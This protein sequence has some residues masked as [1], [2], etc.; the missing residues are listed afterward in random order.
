MLVLARKSL[1]TIRIGDQ[2]TIS[3]VSI[4]GRIVRLGIEAP[5]DL[6]IIRGELMDRDPSESHGES[7]AAPSGVGPTTAAHSEDASSGTPELKPLALQAILPVPRLTTQYVNR[8]LSLRRRPQ[9]S[10]NGVR[11][12]AL[13]V[14]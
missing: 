6:R 4:K 3:V 5:T 9:N 14:S 11:R 7:L 13:A 1:E 2:I 12:P 8:V 10:P